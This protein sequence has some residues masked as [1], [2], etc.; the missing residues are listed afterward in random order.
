[1]RS[2]ERSA[3]ARVKCPEVLAVVAMLACPSARLTSETS[4]PAPSCSV[5]KACRRSKSR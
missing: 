5:A 1:M 4:A 2:T 3:I